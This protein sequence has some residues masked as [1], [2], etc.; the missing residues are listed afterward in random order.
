M[1]LLT[2]LSFVARLWN[3]FASGPG[4][5]GGNQSEGG[6]ESRLKVKANYIPPNTLGKK[7]CSDW[8]LWEENKALWKENKALRVENRALR[9]ENKALQSLP[10]EVQEFYNESLQQVLQQDSKLLDGLPSLGLSNSTENKALQFFRENDVTLKITLKVSLDEVFPEKKESVPVLQEE[11]LTVP[12][13]GKE[14]PAVPE[15]SKDVTAQENGTEATLPQAVEVASEIQ[16]ESGTL[17]GLE[18]NETPVSLPEESEVFMTAEM[19]K[20]TAQFLCSETEA[21]REEKPACPSLPQAAKAISATQEQS[22]ASPVLERSETPVSLLEESDVFVAAQ[23]LKDIIRSLRSK[24]EALRGVRWA[25]HALQGENKILR[26][27]NSKLKLQLGA[28]RGAVNKIMA[29]MDVLQQEVTASAFLL[30]GPCQ[31]KCLWEREEAF[32]PIC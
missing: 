24:N 20:D 9:E 32:V 31:G 26:E 17:P 15:T 14:E 16:E 2:R 23:M 12:L 25:C 19:L 8:I 4:G 1:V 29:Q 30:E 6:R 3:A 18:R 10:M 21:L 7:I 22:R 11:K 5:S 27:E 13:L 28:T